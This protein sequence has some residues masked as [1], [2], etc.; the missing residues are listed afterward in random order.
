VCLE[1]DDL[2]L[3]RG[4][5]CRGTA[6]FSHLACLVNA[7]RADD[8]RWLTCPVCRQQWTGS[9]KLSLARERWALEQGSPEEDGERLMAAL[10]L[11]QALYLAGE[12]DEA[13]QL[14]RDTLAVARRA[15]GDE[16]EGTLDAM[17]RLAVV[18]GDTGN[19]ALALELET[20]VLDVNRR[21]HGSDDPNTLAAANNLAG[22]YADMGSHAAA[23]LLLHGALEGRRRT[24]GDDAPETMITISSLAALHSRLGE[25][26]L[27]LPLTNESVSR[28]RRV[29][30]SEHPETLLSVG[31]LGVLLMRMGSHADAAPLLQ[32]ATRGLSSVYGSG[33]PD[34]VFYQE[35]LDDN[36]RY[37]AEPEAAAEL[38]RFQRQLKLASSQ[39]AVSATVSGLSDRPELEGRDVRVL[40]FG[41]AAALYTVEVVPAMATAEE[42][43]EEGKPELLDLRPA[44]LVLAAGTAIVVVAGP[45]GEEE[46]DGVVCGRRG[47]VESFDA[48]K[49]R[50]SVRVGVAPKL[51]PRERCRVLL[52]GRG[53]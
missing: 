25:L 1:S 14:G 37:L 16:H 13:L 3:Q 24:L 47:A 22:T 18:C 38:Q 5:A 35:E 15:F 51:L 28:Q 39:S 48:E 8:E 32:E 34:A 4:C 33:H 10:D 31:N 49:A 23:L 6:G 7:A 20:E 42:G 46:A 41:S 19:R 36:T 2:P 27:A 43:E 9:L 50:Y 21:L 17:S 29:L 12:L 44:E 53:E 11:V 26:E 45:D 40:R 52:G 30:G